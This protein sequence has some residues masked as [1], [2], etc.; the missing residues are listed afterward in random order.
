ML[1]SFAL[2]ERAGDDIPTPPPM[3]I[4]PP[5]DRTAVVVVWVPEFCPL[6]IVRAVPPIPRRPIPIATSSRVAVSARFG[7]LCPCC[8]MF[9]DASEPAVLGIFAAIV[10]DSAKAELAKTT[11]STFALIIF[12][13]SFP[14]GLCRF[15]VAYTGGRR[16]GKA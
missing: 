4:P 13:F 2:P 14:C 12:Y 9:G 6:V 11:V 3:S 5:I 15:V 7:L 1:P 8:T 16:L 10:L